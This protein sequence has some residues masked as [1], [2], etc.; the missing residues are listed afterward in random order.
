MGGLRWSPGPRPPGTT[1][2]DR[3]GESPALSF[4]LDKALLESH[5]GRANR[6]KEGGTLKGLQSYLKRTRRVKEA[7]FY[8]EKP[9]GFHCGTVQIPHP[10]VQTPCEM[11]HGTTVTF[12]PLLSWESLKMLLPAPAY[13]LLRFPCDKIH[14]PCSLH[15]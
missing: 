7:E 12:K 13:S 1:L 15:S 6:G 9:L 3:T 5:Q 8:S 2:V 4:I 10:C 11:C 14:P